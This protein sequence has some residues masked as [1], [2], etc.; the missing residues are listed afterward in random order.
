MM[1]ISLIFSIQSTS[2]ILKSHFLL[3]Q[4]SLFFEFQGG[5]FFLFN[6]LNQINKKKSD[7]F[8]Y[9]MFDLYDFFIF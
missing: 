3:S 4:L 8:I 1:K 6:F 5:Q 2:T 9:S 7:F